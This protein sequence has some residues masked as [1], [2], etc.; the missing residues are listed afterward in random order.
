MPHL[1]GVEFPIF[2]C[3]QALFS[4]IVVLQHFDFFFF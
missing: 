1:V 3:D 4:R 2:V